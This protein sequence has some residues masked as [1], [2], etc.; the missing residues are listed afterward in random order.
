MKIAAIIAGVTVAVTAATILY[1]KLTWIYNT[2]VRRKNAV[3]YV[4]SCLDALLK[5]RCDLVPNLVGAVKMYMYYETNLLHQLAE[6]RFQAV[7]GALSLSE[8][9]RLDRKMETLMRNIV[10]SVENYPALRASDNFLQLQA[11]LN[12]V[13]EQISAARRA[14][15]AGIME[16]NNTVKMFPT[17][18]MAFFL[19]YREYEW[20]AV[21]ETERARPDVKKLFYR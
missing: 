2:L 3:I 12:E 5:K 11:A 21:L 19:N 1:S 13:E 10:W 6:M 18:I 4:L 7:S 9:V 16:Y 17:N 20:Y 15:S 14:L 8:R